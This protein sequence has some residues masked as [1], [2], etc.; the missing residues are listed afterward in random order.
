MCVY[1]AVVSLLVWPRSSETVRTSAPAS[2]TCV[3]QEWRRKCTLRFF[4]SSPVFAC[5]PC[6]AV[7]ETPMRHFTVH[8][9]LAHPWRRCD[10]PRDARSG[11][12]A[13]LAYLL[14]IRTVHGDIVGSV[15]GHHDS[16]GQFSLRARPRLTTWYTHRSR[17]APPV[18]LGGRMEQGST[19]LPETGRVDSFANSGSRLVQNNLAKVA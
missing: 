11:E 12:R 17:Y 9:A 16:I 1:R 14:P 13:D 3:A 18:A 4:F 7:R 6:V 15:R 8:T 10:R 5:V 19:T 2:K